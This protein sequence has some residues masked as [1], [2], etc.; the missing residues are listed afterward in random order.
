VD[1]Q[2]AIPSA[3]AVLEAKGET[4]ATL[5]PLLRAKLRELA[6]GCVLEVH[7]DDLA[8]REGLPAWSRLTGKELLA[9]VEE[10]ADDLQF[11]LRKK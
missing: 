9:M 6:S 7:T 4:R 1:E 5:T 3:D 2:R 8:A 10:G 11:Y